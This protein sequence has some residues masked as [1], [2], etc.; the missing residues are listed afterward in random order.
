[1]TWHRQDNAFLAGTVAAGAF[2][3]YVLASNFGSAPAPSPFE[4]R[5]GAGDLPDPLIAQ[6]IATPRART[7]F[8]V[9]RVRVDAPRPS[10]T[11]TPLPAPVVA[12][13]P[14]PTPTTAPT[15][16]RKASNVKKAKGVARSER[17]GASGRR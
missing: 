8:V 5:L 4:M 10:V 13:T 14:A 6:V 11:T 16:L 2:V 9:Q 17:A 12:A 15:P 3:M 1:M 7:I